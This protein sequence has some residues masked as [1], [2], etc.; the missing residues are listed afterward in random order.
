LRKYK[1]RP[2]GK[3]RSYTKQGTLLKTQIPIRTFADWT[4]NKVGFCEIDLCGYDTQEQVAILNEFYSVL[5]LYTNF[6]LSV[7]KLK[8]KI[9]IGSKVIKRYDKPTAPYQR[10]LQAKDVSKK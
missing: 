5:R 2:I 7:M 6:F 1:K 10:I 3:G 8:E 4:E 9:R